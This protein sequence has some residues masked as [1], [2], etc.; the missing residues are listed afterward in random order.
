MQ[1]FIAGV[2][3][4]IWKINCVGLYVLGI[5]VNCKTLGMPALVGVHE[6]F[7]FDWRKMTDFKNDIDMI[8][9]DWR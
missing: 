5:V 8:G 2:I 9:G 7:F 6:L 3:A 1:L 4:E